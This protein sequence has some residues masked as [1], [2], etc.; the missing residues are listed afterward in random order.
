MFIGSHCAMFILGFSSQLSHWE[1][2]LFTFWVFLHSALSSELQRFSL[3]ANPSHH[4]TRTQILVNV[5]TCIAPANRLATF[6]ISCPYLL[7]GKAKGKK[8]TPS[9]VTP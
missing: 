6:L 2:S 9:L 4:T 7:F 5:V 3:V 8:K 1:D